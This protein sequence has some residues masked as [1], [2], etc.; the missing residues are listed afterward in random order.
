VSTKF[1]TKL[2]GCNGGLVSWAFKYIIGNG[3]INT[4]YKHLCVACKN[5][6][7]DFDSSSVGVNMTDY[8]NVAPGDVDA[9][10]PSLGEH[11]TEILTAVLK[12]SPDEI[13]KLRQDGVV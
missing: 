9:P 6:Y 10:A 1:H 13:A 8:V 5:Y 4:E 7:C 2:Y 12:M 3:G 11:T